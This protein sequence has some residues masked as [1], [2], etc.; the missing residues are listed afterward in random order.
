MQI[1]AI[2]SWPI[3]SHLKEE[4]GDQHLSPSTA[5]L[6]EGVDFVES[7]LSLLPAEQTK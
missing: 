4:R 3:T 7:P 6:E 2:P 5:S 1:H